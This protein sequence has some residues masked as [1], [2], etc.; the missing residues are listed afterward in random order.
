MTVE[1]AAKVT[2]MWNNDTSVGL[3]RMLMKTKLLREECNISS[4][5][6]LYSYLITEQLQKF[7]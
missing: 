1:M 7:W 3:A 5:V 2:E 4:T 6:F